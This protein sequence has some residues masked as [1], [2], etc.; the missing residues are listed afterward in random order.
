MDEKELTGIK[1]WKVLL[2]FGILI[3]LCLCYYLYSNQT[4][5][6]VEK[7][8]N[9]T[10]KDQKKYKLSFEKI[11]IYSKDNTYYFTCRVLNKTNNEIPLNIVKITLIGDKNISFNSYIG[12][13]IKPNEYRLITMQTK[14]DLSNVKNL[15]IDIAQE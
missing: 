6:Q 13:S 14:E 10:L 2:I 9:I 5:K 1:F 12:T 11:K 15:K 7:K 3:V 8:V 4:K